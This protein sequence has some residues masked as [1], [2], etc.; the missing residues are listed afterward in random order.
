MNVEKYK[1][2]ATDCADLFAEGYTHKNGRIE[3]YEPAEFQM[4]LTLALAMYF[5]A[6][7]PGE[8]MEVYKLHCQSLLLTLEELDARSHKDDTLDISGVAL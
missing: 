2:I 7:F 6:M 4:G 1:Q 5:K 8:L 3:P